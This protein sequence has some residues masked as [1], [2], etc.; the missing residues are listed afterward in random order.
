LIVVLKK[1][2]DYLI[3][4]SKDPRSFEKKIAIASESEVVSLFDRV[5]SPFD[6]DRGFSTP[7]IVWDSFDFKKHPLNECRAYFFNTGK[8]PAGESL[9]EDLGDSDFVPT[10]ILDRALVKGMK[11]PIVAIDGQG[12]EVFKTYGK[13]KKAERRYSKFRE[14]IVPRTRFDVI[15]FKNEPIHLQ[16]RINGIGFDVNLSRF[17]Y[18]ESVKSLLSKVYEKYSTDFYHVSVLEKDD[19]LYLES[20]STS[21]KL[22]PSQ[23]YSMYVKAYESYYETRLPNW[24]KNQAFESQVKPYYQKLNYDSLLLKPKYGIDLKKYGAR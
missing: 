1:F 15:G 3:A 11:F 12:S 4:F 24:F 22:T 9:F 20:A 19:R 2:D 10:A 8:F 7:T 18:L 16:E 6:L 23:S 13:F 14:S 5:K 21:L 17:P